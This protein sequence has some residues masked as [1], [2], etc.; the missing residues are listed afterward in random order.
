MGPCLVCGGVQ[1]TV[2]GYCVNCGNRAAV[3]LE[4]SGVPG[5]PGA[6]GTPDV[7]PP[8]RNR[9]LIVVGVAAVVALAVI[10]MV[11]AGLWAWSLTGSKHAAGPGS[12]AS[13]VAEST[14]TSGPTPSSTPVPTSA[15]PLVGAAC[16]LGNWRETSYQTDAV[17]FGV[18]VRLTGAGV[19]QTF[20]ADG[21]NTYQ[22]GA[23]I[24][25]TGKQ[26]GN[27]YTLTSSGTITS[28]YEVIGNQIRYSNIQ[29]TGTSVWKRNG[30]QIAKQDLTGQLGGETFVCTGDKLILYGTNYTTELDRVLG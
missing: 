25:E 30:K 1:Y 20:T 27:T 21:T 7:A 4:A 13:P 18:T 8:G 10:V 14:P 29:A 5:V 12:S 22:L 9:T 15:A 26:G 6:P 24:T 3:Q 11:G 28:H 16:L 17:I 2:D 19:T 23:G